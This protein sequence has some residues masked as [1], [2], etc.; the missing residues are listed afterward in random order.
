MKTVIIAMLSVA[1]AIPA[2]TS[3]GAAPADLLIGTPSQDHIVDRSKPRI[4]GGSGCDEPQDRIE[5]P[6]CR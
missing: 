4:K 2:L 3:A 1:V 6:E 5:H